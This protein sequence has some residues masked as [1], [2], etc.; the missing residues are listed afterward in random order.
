MTNIDHYLDITILPNTEISGNQ[1]MSILF[2]KLHLALVSYG[3]KDIGVSFPDA[4]IEAQQTGSQL[5]LHGQQ[6]SLATLMASGWATRFHDYALISDILQVPEHTMFRT[7]FRVQEKQSNPE[8]LRRRAMKRHGF[9]EEEAK[10][11]I[12]DQAQKHLRLPFIEM[13]S[14][15]SAQ[16]FR[17]FFDYGQLEAI[18]HE[19]KFNTYGF[20]RTTTVPWF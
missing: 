4:N 15:S 2:E 1:I 19:G 3:Q 9:D 10:K 12:P 14:Y 13:K 16:R 8:R 20:S 11:R 7:V 17:L 18:S 6:K 5:R